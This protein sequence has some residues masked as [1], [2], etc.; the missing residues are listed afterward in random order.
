MGTL[1]GDLDRLLHDLRGPLNALTIHLEA[2]KRAGPDDPAG[3]QSLE[4]ARLEVARLAQL[5]PAAFDVVALECGRVSR[6]N[7][8]ALVRDAVERHGLAPATVADGVWPDVDGDPDLLAL[9]VAHLVRNALAAAPPAG[10]S[11]SP[12]HV[13][14]RPAGP[15]RVA[16]VVR[17]WGPGL[18]T[19]NSRAL[20]RLTISPV[21]GRPAIG[22]LTVERVAR[23]HGGA[24]NLGAAASGGAEAVLTLPTT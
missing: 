6:L 7:L 14:C 10:A 16:V 24:L 11:P 9:A 22:L 17:D 19:A 20:I 23:L 15:G 5:L 1:P 21:T 3:L 8:G 12:P 18:R 13:S 2:V 4:A